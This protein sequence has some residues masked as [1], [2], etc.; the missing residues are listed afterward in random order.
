VRRLFLTAVASV[1][2][3]TVAA[4]G[5]SRG[6]RRLRWCGDN[7]SDGREVG[8]VHAVA[9]GGSTVDEGEREIG[10]GGDGSSGAGGE[11][12]EMSLPPIAGSDRPRF[13]AQN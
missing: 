7:A 8:E 2:W 12:A 10:G 1:M 9:G 4:S 11:Q 3:A 6:A 13:D 5:R